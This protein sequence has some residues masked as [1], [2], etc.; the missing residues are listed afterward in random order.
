MLLKATEANEWPAGVRWSVGKQREI[1]VPKG[2]EIP[3]WLVQVKDKKSKAKK[4]AAKSD[5]A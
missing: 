2:A 4:A 3:D 1:E 5:E